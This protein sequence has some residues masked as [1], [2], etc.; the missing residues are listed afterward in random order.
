MALISDFINIRDDNDFIINYFNKYSDFL[1]K[2]SLKNFI[3]DIIK[4]KF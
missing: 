4:V 3:K 2:N 1:L